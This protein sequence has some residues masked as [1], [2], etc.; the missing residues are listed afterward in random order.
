MTTTGHTYLVVLKRSLDE[1]DFH[2]IKELN[3]LVFKRMSSV[4][5]VVVT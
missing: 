5:G 1:F 3:A 4:K 2:T